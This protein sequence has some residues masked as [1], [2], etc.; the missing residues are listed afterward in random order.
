MSMDATVVARVMLEGYIYLGWAY[1]DAQ[2]RALSWRSF[3]LVYDLE[4]LLERKANGEEVDELE[5]AELRARLQDEAGRFYTRGAE[6]KDYANPYQRSWTY[7]KDGNR[8][9]LPQMISEFGDPNLKK[10][11][12]ELSQLGHWTARGMGPLVKRGTEQ[13]CISFR[14]NGNKTRACAVLVQALAGMAGIVAA[15]FSLPFAENL[16]QLFDAYLRALGLTATL[17]KQ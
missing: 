15:H 11:Y 16:N 6:G 5:E 8:V 9:V 12:D 10:L 17:R 7:D 13:V 1:N 14:S 3:V 2:E 4:T